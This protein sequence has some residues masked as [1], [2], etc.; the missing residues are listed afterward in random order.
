MNF[1]HLH[2]HSQYSFLDGAS[3]ID[4]LLEKAQA[5]AMPALALT[6]HNR[7]TG[8]IRF[9]EKA[10]ACGIKPII[11]A[12][13]DVEGGRHLT[14]LCKDKQGYSNLCRLLTE[15]RLSNRDRQPQTEKRCAGFARGLSPCLV[16]I[17][18]RFLTSLAGASTRRRLGPPAST[19]THTRAISS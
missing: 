4:R 7:L 10:I 18:V 13:V 11:G 17:V 5:L 3:S 1:V 16:V 14:L 12:E 15:T 19:E 8:A 6:D 9:Y 2:V